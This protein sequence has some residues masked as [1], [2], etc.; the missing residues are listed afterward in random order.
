MP[1]RMGHSEW[2]S[3][4]TCIRVLDPSRVSY[5]TRVDI[6]RRTLHDRGHALVPV[7]APEEMQGLW[8]ILFGLI[9]TWW[10]YADR[11]VRRFSAPYEFETFAFFAWPVVVPYYLYRTRGRRG[12]ALIFGVGGLFIA[13]YLVAAIIRVTLLIRALP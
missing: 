4:P 6:C 5:R 9:L 1:R 12:L 8:M 2:L 10:L 3:S 7:P 11:Q 13:P